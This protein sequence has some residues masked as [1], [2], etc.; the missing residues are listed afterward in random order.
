MVVYGYLRCSTLVQD[1]SH[2]RPEI[3][4]Y[5]NKFNLGEIIWVEDEGIS[6][7][8]PWSRRKIFDIVNRCLAGDWVICQELSRLSRVPRDILNIR[9]IFDEKRVNF[10][11]VKQDL[12]WTLNPSISSVC[13]TNMKTMMYS[14]FAQMERDTM[15]ARIKTGMFNAMKDRED[16]IERIARREVVAGMVRDGVENNR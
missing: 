14:M 15:I 8:R 13:D 7:N 9:H 3:E 12:T 16:T 2:G 6:G 11:A 1:I 10:H 5:V 4:A